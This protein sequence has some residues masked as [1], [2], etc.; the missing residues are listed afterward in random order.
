MAVERR[1]DYQGGQVEHP[2]P[3]ILQKPLQSEE[4]IRQKAIE[5]EVVA[6]IIEAANSD[7]TAHNFL[8]RAVEGN[9]NRILKSPF[10]RDDEPFVVVG[11]YPD[12]RSFVSATF[13]KEEGADKDAD[14]KNQR[15]IQWHAEDAPGLSP[16]YFSVDLEELRKR[17]VWRLET[18]GI[19]LSNLKS[20]LVSKSEGKLST[21]SFSQSFISK[22]E[23]EGFSH[24]VEFKKEDDFEEISVGSTYGNIEM[25]GYKQTISIKV[26]PQGQSAFVFDSQQI[27]VVTADFNERVGRSR[28][29]Y[30]PDT[31]LFC[32]LHPHI[33][34]KDNPSAFLRINL[35]LGV[36]PE[37]V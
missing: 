27:E 22:L 12:D 3:P 34:E 17:D 2:R 19:A 23:G 24:N 6:E 31:R 1:V 26:N 15:E 8:K 25:S 18:A 21:D 5:Q 28:S 7:V 9:K 29:G 37:K 14:E 11:I 10:I 35:A 4:T 13:E 16:E 33:V 36:L 32:P 30:V 20:Y